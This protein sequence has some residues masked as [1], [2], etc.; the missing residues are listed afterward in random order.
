[1]ARSAEPAKLPEEIS[2]QL[3]LVV[4]FHRWSG[5]PE[6]VT[7]GETIYA[8][9]FSRLRGDSRELQRL[10]DSI[11]GYL[12]GR[13]PGEIETLLAAGRMYRRSADYHKAAEYFLKAL[14][15]VYREY[16]CG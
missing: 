6:G 2:R 13:L 7:E 15:M 8:D 3:R 12:K 9:Q 4:E 11:A 5:S 1:M 10:C 14:D 16:G